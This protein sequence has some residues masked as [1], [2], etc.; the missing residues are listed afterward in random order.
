MLNSGRAP[1]RL[2]FLFLSLVIYSPLYSTHPDT[3]EHCGDVPLLHHWRPKQKQKE[4]N[5]ARARSSAAAAVA[6]AEREVPSMIQFEVE[7]ASCSYLG[8]FAVTRCPEVRKKASAGTADSYL[9]WWPSASWKWLWKW[10]LSTSSRHQQTSFFVDIC[11]RVMFYEH[12]ED[13]ER[14]CE[15][16]SDTHTLCYRGRKPHWASKRELR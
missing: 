7:R 12:S 9:H 6:P 15:F 10:A 1:C 3:T 13:P 4:L 2:L 8:L 16:T 11:G 5:N 14:C